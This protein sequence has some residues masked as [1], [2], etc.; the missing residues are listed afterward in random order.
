M[1][2]FFDRRSAL[3]GLAALP[4]GGL[5]GCGKGESADKAAQVAR[6]VVLKVARKVLSVADVVLTIKD[7]AV[8]IAAIIDGRPETITS[9]ITEDEAAAL[10]DGGQLIIKSEDGTEIPVSY[11][12]K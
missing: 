5:F 8:E 11:Q 1:P 12:L 6:T 2:K 10:R 3:V 7:L 9:R 4:F